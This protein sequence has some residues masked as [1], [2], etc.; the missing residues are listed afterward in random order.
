MMT[1]KLGRKL[2]RFELVHHKDGNPYNFDPDNLVL[3]T[4]I[5]HGRW[6]NL[7]RPRDPKSTAKMLKTREARKKL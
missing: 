1:I 5:D 2:R 4:Q 7:G 3:T 6:H